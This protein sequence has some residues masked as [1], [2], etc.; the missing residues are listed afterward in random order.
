[1]SETKKIS[2]RR[3]LVGVVVSAKTAKTRVVLVERVLEHHKYGKRFRSSRRLAAH[4]E[5]NLYQVGDKVI[6]EQT[7]PRSRTK[8]WRVVTKLI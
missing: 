1:M 3:R 8:R 2:S 5:K 6:I 4:D 7:R